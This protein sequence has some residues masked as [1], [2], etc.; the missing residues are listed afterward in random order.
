G[1]NNY[2]YDSATKEGN[3]WSDWSGSGSY[4]IGGYA[5]SVDLYPLREPLIFEYPQIVLL[6]LLL[7]IVTLFL[8][9]TIS[10]KKKKE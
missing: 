6:T 2:W 9:R 4:F 8:T 10:K 1:A 3:Y 7:S 5:Y